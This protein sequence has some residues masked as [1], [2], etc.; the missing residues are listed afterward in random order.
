MTCTCS[1]ASGTETLTLDAATCIATGRFGECLFDSSEFVGCS[2]QGDECAQACSLL[3]SRTRDEAVSAPSVSVRV[4]TCAADGQCRFVL[5]SDL[6]CVT[7]P[8]LVP[9]DCT[10]AEAAL[11]G[12]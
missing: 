3:W 12:P 7:G 10:D 9:S 4:S 1:G 8:A 11:T 5:E 2:V 6:G